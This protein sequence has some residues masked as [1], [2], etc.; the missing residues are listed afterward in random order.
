M[1]AIDDL[2]GAGCRY[3][4]IGQHLAPSELHAPVLR[5]VHPDELDEWALRARSRV[6]HV[7]AGP[8]MRCSYRV[9]DMFKSKHLA[10]GSVLR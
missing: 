8:H 1:A 5:S 4:A 6:L 3:L 10:Y 2:I 9:G 7:T